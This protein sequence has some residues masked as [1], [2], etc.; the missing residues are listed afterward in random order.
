MR[1]RGRCLASVLAVTLAVPPAGVRWQ[2]E[3]PLQGSLVVV[4]VRPDSLPRP[5]PVTALLGGMAG[6]EPLHFEAT[7]AG[8]GWWALAPV[9]LS[10]ADTLDVSVTVER[11]SATTDTVV[12]RV[13]VT[14]RTFHS[15]R[16]HPPPEYRH[17]PDSSVV[18]RLA[19]ESEQVAVVFRQTH[20]T[21]RLWR[22]GFV[23]PVPGKINS[24]FG[25]RRAFGEGIEGRHRGVD[26]AA[27]LGHPVLATNRG[28]VALVADQY[29]G[30]LTVLIDHGAGLVTGYEHLSSA[31]V[32]VGDTVA[33]G[34]VVGKVGATGRATGPHLHWA[35]FYGRVAVD[36]LQLLTL[37]QP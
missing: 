2:P 18:A 27:A 26:L 14:E 30:G 20:A 4:T 13:P 5:A 3:R 23:R 8:V 7:A 24:A 15:E 21:P 12:T 37:T 31:A 10:T 34:S 1:P 36:P 25:A 19:A 22:E 33:R 6:G 29:Y 28:V 9:P 11:D 32:S 17:P 16:L 35:A